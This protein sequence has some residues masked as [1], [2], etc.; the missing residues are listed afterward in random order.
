MFSLFILL[1]V[2][3][4]DVLFAGLGSTGCYGCDYVFPKIGFIISP[5]KP[6]LL[7]I[8]SNLSLVFEMLILE[9]APCS[10]F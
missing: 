8:D 7:I 4:L 6:A 10:N 5:L 1:S 3:P 2:L 9:R